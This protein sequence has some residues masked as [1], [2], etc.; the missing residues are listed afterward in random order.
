MR[1]VLPLALL[2]FLAGS[3]LYPAQAAP[4]RVALDTPSDVRGLRLADADGDGISDVLVIDA[5]SVRIHRGRRDGLPAAKPTWVTAAPEGVSFVDVARPGPDGAPALMA[6]GRAGA[7]RMPLARPAPA[8]AVDET[9]G[10]SWRDASK[11]TF[12]DL[13]QSDGALLLPRRGGWVY[14]RGTNPPVELEL[15]A[16]RTVRA[17]GPFLEDTC[18]SVWALPAVFVGA[19]AREAAGADLPCLWSVRGRAMVAGTAAGRVAY[20]LSFLESEGGGER[21]TQRLVD[22]DGDRRP[23]L[24]HRVH[25]TRETRYGFFRTRP[26]PAGTKQGPS[27]KPAA[28]ALY[29][30]G[31]QFDPEYEDLDGDGL[32]DLVVT[33]VA[34]NPANTFQA[35]ATG[36][37]TAE[38]LA[39][40]NRWGEGKGSY[41]RSEP[42]A[43]V[44]SL[45]RVDVRFNYA[46]TIEVD[47]F[48]TI[49]ADG[50]LDGD[51]RKDLAI[52]TADDVVTVRRGTPSGVWATEGVSVE[53]P[54]RG[55]HPD[56]EGYTADLDGDGRDEMV[57][58]YRAPPKGGDRL[59]I[60]R[61]P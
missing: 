54:P 33:S 48:F 58:L 29:L 60:V 3:T 40:L 28:S 8:E 26:V 14:R 6:F 16:F 12:A 61:G 45:V 9:D 22:L 19:P 34:I 11:L 20:D 7:Q 39:F 44:K 42:D 56:I 47:R 25:A 4:E 38:T 51:G 53:I 35:M 41:F 27:H 50:D 21:V 13:T 59:W 46:G 36:K 23:E 10:L 43:A 2:A 5:R 18:E 49:M 52:R 17:P 24:V 15:G 37:V 57:L 55:A 31:Y 1:R 30:T 32:P